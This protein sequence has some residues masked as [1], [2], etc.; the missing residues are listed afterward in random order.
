MFL[1]G[2]HHDISVPDLGAGALVKM[3][4]AVCRDGADPRLFFPC[5]VRKAGLGSC[6]KLELG[7]A[8]QGSCRWREC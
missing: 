7:A 4:G 1:V 6:D 3:D 8:S 2:I 5:S